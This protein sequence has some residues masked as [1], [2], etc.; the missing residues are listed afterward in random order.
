MRIVAWATCLG[1]LALVLG[2]C[3]GHDAALAELRGNIIQGYVYYPDITRAAGAPATAKIA[4][5]L[6]DGQCPV[7]GAT[8]TLVQTGATVKTNNQGFFRLAVQD[9]GVYLLRASHPAFREPVSISVNV[10]GDLTEANSEMGVGFY[11]LAGVDNYAYVNHLQGPLNDVDGL[12]STIPVFLGRTILLKDAAATKSGL[13]AAFTNAAAKM[14]PND[15]L[16][17]YFSGHGGRDAIHDY[18]CPQDTLLDSFDNDLT[19]TELKDWIEQLPDPTRVVV[20]L[21]TCFSGSF[22]D[23]IDSQA[24]AKRAPVA[25]PSFRSLSKVG[26]TVLTASARDQYSWEGMDNFGVIRGFFSRHLMIGLS[27][28]KNLADANSDRQITARELFDYASTRT[29]AETQNYQVQNPQFQEGGN[30]VILRY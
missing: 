27:G 12:A 14:Q 7:G 29:I 10:Q 6:A 16:I 9:Y 3:G 11:I 26:C 2:G 4:P 5:R 21:D 8:V 18:I 22:I 25:G 28:E 15:F 24:V 30:P 13:H 1:L 23:G 20:I 17:F 19:D